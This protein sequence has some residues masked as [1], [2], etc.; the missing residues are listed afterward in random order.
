MYLTIFA[1][2]IRR[3][4]CEREKIAFSVNVLISP[5]LVCTERTETMSENASNSLSAVGIDDSERDLDLLDFHDKTFKASS[6]RPLSQPE[7]IDDLQITCLY[8]RY[9]FNSEYCI[10]FPKYDDLTLQF[11]FL[12][13]A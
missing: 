9:C 11:L 12:S 7:N 4:N 1:V 3:L 10:T 8:S 13:S 6:Q 5:S 2:F